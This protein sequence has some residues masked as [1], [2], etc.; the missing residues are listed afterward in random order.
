MINGGLGLL[1]SSDGT[2]GDYIAYGVVAGVVWVSY[3]SVA[4]CVRD[5]GILGSGKDRY[6]E[7]AGA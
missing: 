1:F 3:I 5:L 4:V 7:K 6:S 2:K